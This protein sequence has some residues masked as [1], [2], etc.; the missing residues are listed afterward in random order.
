MDCSGNRMLRLLGL[1]SD[2]ANDMYSKH[3]SENYHDKPQ[4]A[5]EPPDVVVQD[6]WALLCWFLVSLLIIGI[7]LIILFKSRKVYPLTEHAGAG[8]IKQ[9]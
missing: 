8:H 5:P 3:H 4:T 7:L 1:C 9:G 6:Y 2:T